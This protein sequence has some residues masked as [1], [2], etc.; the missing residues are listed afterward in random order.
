M[1]KKIAKKEGRS[2]IFW[3]AV[4]LVAGIVFGLLFT[5]VVTT[6]QAVK[7][8]NE[9]A[10]AKS[11]VNFEEARQNLTLD[12]LNVNTIKNRINPLSIVSTNDVDFN[13]SNS[14]QMF[15]GNS[16]IKLISGT[17]TQSQ[18]N[19]GTEYTQVN[20]KDSSMEIEL[21]A[22]QVKFSGL[23]QEETPETTSALYSVGDTFIASTYIV[24]VIHIWDANGIVEMQLRKD[25][26]SNTVFYAEG[27]YIIPNSVQVDSIDSNTV[28]VKFYPP[29]NA[30]LCIRQ[31]GRIYR[32]F[33]PCTE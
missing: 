26:L 7:A 2:Y 33:T 8:L 15:A 6:G 22:P 18:I 12:T 24:E 13:V 9:K 27:D 23:H 30:Y 25:S 19:I 32:S 29:T 16:A 14:I 3:A 21:S 17:P 4:C 11:T 10:V 5:N 28:G 20:L 1:A 31:D